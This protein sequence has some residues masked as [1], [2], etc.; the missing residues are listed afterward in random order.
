MG[1]ATKSTDNTI[2]VRFLPPSSDVN[3]WHLEEHFSQVGPIKKCSVISNKEKGGLGYGFVKFVSQ[4]DALTASKQC[5]D[6]FLIVD[7]KNYKLKVTLASNQDDD[8]KS[9][10]PEKNIIDT[11]PQQQSNV[12]KLSTSQKEVESQ[13]HTVT[14]IPSKE[15]ESEIKDAEELLLAKRKRTCR[16]IIRNLSF[17]A[18]ENHIRTVLEK[19]YGPIVEIT[20]PRVSETL[21]RGFCFVTFE[22]ALHAR[23]ATEPRKEPLNIKN[24]AVA[25]DFALAKA[26]HQKSR[27]ETTTNDE[28]SSDNDE[29]K[30][31]EEDEDHNMD[32]AAANQDEEGKDDD[33]SNE[34]NDDDD[35]DEESLVE[36][37]NEK[38]QLDSGSKTKKPRHQ[39]PEIDEGVAQSKTIF[40]RN[41]PFDTTRDDIF[42]LMRKFG[43]IESIYPV[44]EKDT[45]VFKG[46]AFC[47][48]RDSEAASRALEASATSGN[49]N[50]SQRSL[51]AEGGEGIQLRGRRIFIDLAVDKQTASTLTLE[52]KDG[53]KSSGKDKRCLYLSSEGYVSSQTADSNVTDIKSWENLPE[54]DQLKRQRAL[55]DKTTK[56]KSPLFFI[57]PTRLSI[58]NLAKHVDEIVLKDLCVKALRLGL[59]NNLVK[60][61]DQVAFWRASLGLGT[62]EIMKKLN[63]ATAAEDKDPI[64]PEF[65]EKN[66]KRFIPSVFIDRDF[67]S[68][69]KEKGVSRGFGFV[70]FTHHIHAL[71]CLRELNNNIDYSAEYVANGKQALLLRGKRNKPSKKKGALQDG[72]N[73]NSVRIPRLIVEFTV[74]NKVKAQQQVAKREKQRANATAQ[75]TE[76]SSSTSKPQT[77]TTTTTKKSRGALQRERKRL[78]QQQAEGN[79]EKNEKNQGGSKESEEI[80]T[81]H[82]SIQINN[83]STEVETKPKKFK[84]RKKQKLED[85]KEDQ[86][87]ESLVQNHTKPLL[88]EDKMLHSKSKQ[89]KDKRWFE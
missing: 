62:R 50:N 45:G 81:K 56:L 66:V 67:S 39:A 16:V 9:R 30:D 41:L 76:A 18:N 63:E 52:K 1:Q 24:R 88:A 44:M 25:I 48:F 43:H 13:K 74:E 22:S 42:Q 26:V 8:G 47:T 5:N 4:Q 38:T 68:S 40:L 65:Q 71:A 12:K 51:L 75:Q 35:D 73:Q 85:Q 10:Q 15:N 78:R 33:D 49:L 79:G 7:G 57:N 20:L 23:K 53:I 59:E 80:S 84:P 83:S 31:N 28:S 60:V 6:T 89:T 82:D 87:F 46:T 64:I 32:D 2:F 21:H 11:K 14:N 27:N 72:D 17:Y 19:E 70:D 36:S 69:K 3:R 61:D 55:T 29:N 37:E 54:S 86:L 34:E 77:T 58:R